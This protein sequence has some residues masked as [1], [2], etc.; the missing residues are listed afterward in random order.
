MSG[1]WR[2][3]SCVKEKGLFLV[4][5]ELNVDVLVTVGNKMIMKRTN[6]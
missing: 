1:P 4:V 6:S 3:T 5:C 2:F